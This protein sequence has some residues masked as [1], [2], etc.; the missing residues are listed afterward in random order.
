MLIL[1]FLVCSQVTSIRTMLT[2][3]AVKHDF[4]A[5]E[6]AYFLHHKQTPA[7]RIVLIMLGKING[8]LKYWIK[9]GN[10]FL[11]DLIKFFA[12]VTVG[13]TTDCLNQGGILPKR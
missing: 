5:V 11:R 1:R 4:V 10:M 7:Y 3:K 2:Q 12:A 13:D 9:R 6:K 8:I